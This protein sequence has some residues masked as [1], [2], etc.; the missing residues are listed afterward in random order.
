MAE[1]CISKKKNPTQQHS[2]WEQGVYN[3]SKLK[4]FKYL[5]K[6]KPKATYS[7]TKTDK[8]LLCASVITLGE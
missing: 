6:E 8:L 7:L 2:G 1:M 5:N 3:F 4:Y